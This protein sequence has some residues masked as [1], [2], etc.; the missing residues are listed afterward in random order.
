M[1][2]RR[3]CVSWLTQQRARNYILSSSPLDMPIAPPTGNESLLIKPM[4]VPS[5]SSSEPNYLE[6]IL[7]TGME[8]ILDYLL[9]NAMNP[10]AKNGEIVAIDHGP[11]QPV[12]EQETQEPEPMVDDEAWGK[13]PNEEKPSLSV[14]DP[15][16][17][18]K[19]R[20]QNDG[21]EEYMATGQSIA[22]EALDGHTQ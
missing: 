8:T 17:L 12:E 6:C 20:R 3:S 4:G 16:L 10:K 21:W 13:L 11:P 22:K 1:P 7:I 5:Y 9:R 15:S 19:Q 2:Q 14:F 18:D